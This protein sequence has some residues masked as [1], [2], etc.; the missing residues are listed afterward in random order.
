MNANSHYNNELKN[1]IFDRMEEL[2][3]L[4]ITTGFDWKAIYRNL[5]NNIYPRCID[6]TD[7]EIDREIELF[8]NA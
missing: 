5:I 3:Y 2:N 1:R 7:D 4:D 8:Y 6:A